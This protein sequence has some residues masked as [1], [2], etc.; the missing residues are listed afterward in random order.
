MAKPRQMSDKALAAAIAREEQTEAA[1]VRRA[2][3]AKQQD[4][5]TGIAGRAYRGASPGD[6]THN[7]DGT[8]KKYAPRLTAEQQAAADA[9]GDT[10][11]DAFGSLG[12]KRAEH[13]P[14]V[15]RA[16]REGAAL[17]RQD[18]EETAAP[19]APVAAPAFRRGD[20]LEM[21][22]EWQRIQAEREALRRARQN[23][24]RV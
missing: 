21:Q 17:E 8:R 19:S 24:R 1:A 9:V 5:R 4:G 22:A 14:S 15:E 3:L 6:P 7:P 10:M 12:I 11:W 16:I 23:S 13:S 18:A 2:L 20:T